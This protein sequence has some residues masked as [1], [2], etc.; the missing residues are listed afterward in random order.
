MY[1]CLCIY[2]YAY[3]FMYIC[4]CIYVYEYMLMYIIYLKRMW[5]VAF[6][7]DLFG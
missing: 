1:I 3:M 7:S 6:K 5:Q 2:V 4:L